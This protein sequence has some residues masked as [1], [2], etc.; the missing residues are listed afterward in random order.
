MKNT[1]QINDMQAFIKTATA[2]DQLMQDVDPY[3]YR[4]ADGCLEDTF[5]ALENDPCAVIQE[6]MEQIR[7]MMDDEPDDLETIDETG[8]PV[9]DCDRCPDSFKCEALGGMHCYHKGG[10]DNE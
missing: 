2:L 5:D 1:M 3:G 4:D 6:L 8:H 10:K 9:M 7:N